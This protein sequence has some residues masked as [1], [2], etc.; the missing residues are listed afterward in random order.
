[1]AI[2]FA[3]SRIGLTAVVDLMHAVLLNGAKELQEK[4]EGHAE[5]LLHANI[6][7]NLL[8]EWEKH[9]GGG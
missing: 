5:D 9:C 4:Q 6:L 7:I 1:M 3:G 2:C 8:F